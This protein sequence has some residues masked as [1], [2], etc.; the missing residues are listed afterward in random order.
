[1]PKSK[2]IIILA[3]QQLQDTG[4]RREKCTPPRLDERVLFPNQ[5]DPPP[6]RPWPATSDEGNS[7]PPPKRGK[8]SQGEKP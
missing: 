7:V 5:S 4:E 8:K 1:M 6:Q 3:P 2:P